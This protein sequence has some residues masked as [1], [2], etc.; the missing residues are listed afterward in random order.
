MKRDALSAEQLATQLRRQ[1]VRSRRRAYRLSLVAGL[2]VIWATIA[3]VAAWHLYHEDNGLGEAIT[4]HAD[5]EQAIGTAEALMSRL[6]RRINERPEDAD[7][8]MTRILAAAEE[9]FVALFEGNHAVDAGRLRRNARLLSMLGA[10]YLALDDPERAARAATRAR[11]FLERLEH[12]FPDDRNRIAAT[13]IAEGDALVALHDFDGAVAAYATASAIRGALSAAAPESEALLRALGVAF[14]REGQALAL[15]GATEEAD[16]RLRQALAIRDQ[17]AAAAGEDDAAAL[18]PLAIAYSNLGDLASRAHSHDQATEHYRKAL[19]LYARLAEIKPDKL[20]WR[21]A[22]AQHL[23]R[24]GRAEAGMGEH[25]AAFDSFDQAAEEYRA[26]AEADPSSRRW[27]SRLADVLEAGGALKLDR[28]DLSGAR[29]AYT[30]ALDIRRDHAERARPGT[31][32]IRAFADTL[33]ALAEVD[34]AE[35]LDEVARLRLDAAIELR[36]EVLAAEP[37]NAM[38]AAEL[39]EALSAGAELGIAP[40]LHLEEALEV[41]KRFAEEEQLRREHQPLAENIR[42]RL[43]SFSQ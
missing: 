42:Q 33:A 40:R 8:Q 15:R 32:E 26:L 7:S 28:H 4:A 16:A 19:E 35:N 12:Q 6:A 25:A 34:R 30:R 27:Q 10:S 38:A 36:R 22:H 29:S 43:A 3:T 9:D 41:L 17:L 21:D 11:D 5:A 31:A 23:A 39:A 2:A 18:E 14:E 1:T 24:I 37:A 13:F 20:T